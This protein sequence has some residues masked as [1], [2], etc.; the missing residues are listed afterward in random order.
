MKRLGQGPLSESFGPE[1][2]RGSVLRRQRGTNELLVVSAGDLHERA[3]IEELLIGGWQSEG[4]G[5]LPTLAEEPFHTGRPE[6]QEQAGFRR[7]DMERVCDAAR[8]IDKRAGHRCEQG[9]T[10][11]DTN[12]AGEEYEE[13][14]LP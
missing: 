7:I 4:S 11:L 14:V 5:W 8:A 13:P 6:E 12:L 9:L 1:G 10:V 3:P 2:L